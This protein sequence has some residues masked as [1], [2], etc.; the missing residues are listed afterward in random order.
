MG[1]GLE[2]SEVTGLGLVAV[3]ARKGV[4]AEAIGQ[5]L[6]LAPGLAA[7][8]TPHWVGDGALALIG[9]G[10]GSWLARSEAPT[11]E[12]AETV[13]ERLAGLASATDVSASYRVFRLSG[14]DAAR[15]LQRGAFVDLATPA[16]APGSVAVTVI[17][18][19]GVIIRQIDETSFDVSVFR[20]LGESFHHWL[21]TAAATL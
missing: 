6:G 16:F 5:R 9:T 21:T 10:P 1:D 8:A 14:G 15:L 7:P 3:M 2:I 17:A 18:H 4:G 12:W 11:A 19:I 13:I 20:S